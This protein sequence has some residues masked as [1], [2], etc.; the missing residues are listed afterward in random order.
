MK[1][2]TLI[3]F[4]WR[5]LLFEPFASL[6]L[7]RHTHTRRTLFTRVH[8]ESCRM[9][10]MDEESL[11][12]VPDALLAAFL[13]SMCADPMI[14]H[15]FRAVKL[16]IYSLIQQ[17]HWCEENAWKCAN[18]VKILIFSPFQFPERKYARFFFLFSIFSISS[19]RKGIIYARDKHLIGFA[20]RIC[21][22]NWG[23]LNKRITNLC[24]PIL[25][26]MTKRNEWQN[27]LPR[28]EPTANSCFLIKFP[29]EWSRAE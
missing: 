20:C 22:Q 3:R 14:T 4:R 26:S 24:W 11:C 1:E 15:Y 25:A 27:K 13:C 28:I 2:I 16:L 18:C 7:A 21:F 10:C 17:L 5:L 19:S 23:K 29:C 6:V 12:C 9:Q 8:T